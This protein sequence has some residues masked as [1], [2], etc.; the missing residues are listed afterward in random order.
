MNRPRVVL[1]LIVAFSY[2]CH[3]DPSPSPTTSQLADHTTKRP[4]VPSSPANPSRLPSN[5]GSRQDIDTDL[6]DEQKQ[7]VSFPAVGVKLVRPSGF[8]DAENFHG[9]QQS[10]TQASVMVVMIPGPFSE[11]T[12]GFNAGQLKKNGMTLHSK[13]NVEIDGKSGVLLGVT[14]NAY[15]TDFAKWILAIGNETQTSMVTATFPQTEGANLSEEMKAVVLSTKIDDTSATTTSADVGFAIAPSPKLKVVRGIGKMLIYTT[16]GTIP[17]KSRKD[18]LFIA[19]RSF[20][21]VSVDDTRQFAVKRLF[22]TAHTKIGAV[23]YN[24][25]ITIDGLD[26]YE[27]LAEGEDADSGTPLK[28]YQVLLYDDGSYILIQ[29]LAGANVADDYLPE[30]K[31]MAQS[32]TRTQK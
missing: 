4:S 27:I 32:L 30:F 15:G 22:Q 3:G 20:S 9:F 17:A 21:T 7:Y 8:D 16:D 23:S 31:A 12:S 19:A 10:T 11:V 5:N 6:G 24:N 13:D 18:A 2:G 26:G 29:G 1:I 28:V 25:E 14:Q